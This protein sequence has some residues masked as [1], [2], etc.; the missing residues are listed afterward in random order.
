MTKK[1]LKELDLIRNAQG[2]FHK[3]LIV[4]EELLHI[5]HSDNHNKFSFT[6]TEFRLKR[7]GFTWDTPPKRTSPEL[8]HYINLGEM[9]GTGF[10]AP[11]R[12]EKKEPLQNI[13]NRKKNCMTKKLII[14][15]VISFMAGVIYGL[16]STS[17]C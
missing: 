13:T 4:D 2:G 6:S 14:I 9:G 1:E 16:I 15:T 12:R 17:I 11:A 5:S 3:I 7:A 8:I 10:M